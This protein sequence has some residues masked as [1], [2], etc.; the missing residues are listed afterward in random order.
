M[1]MNGGVLPVLA[2]FIA[3]GEEQGVP[4]S[5]LAGTIQNDI[6]KEVRRLKRVQED[7]KKTAT[8]HHTALHYFLRLATLVPRYAPQFMVRNTYIYPPKSSMRVIADIFGY[9]SSHMPK[10][11]SISISGYH[12]QEA[13][14]DAKLELGFTIADGL[15]Y[16]RTAE[17]AGLKVRMS[18]IQS[19]Q[20]KLN[21]TPKIT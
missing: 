15:E 5:S 11:N 3:T 17:K 20:K 10:Y 7:R 8:P 18:E 19:L 1:T 2:M 13:G 21:L 6:L 4:I 16:V 12:M 9:T 14:A